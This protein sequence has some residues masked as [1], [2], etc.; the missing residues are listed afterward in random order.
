MIVALTGM[1]DEAASDLA[2]ELALLRTSAGGK[3]LLVPP[4][5][6]AGVAGKSSRLR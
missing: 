6:R 1:D 3:V 4:S 2:Q 5:Q